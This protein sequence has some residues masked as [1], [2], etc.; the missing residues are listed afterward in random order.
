MQILKW[1]ATSGCHSNRPG[2]GK[3]VLLVQKMLFE[4]YLSNGIKTFELCLPSGKG[5]ILI[6]IVT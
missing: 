4:A 5:V 2:S 1:R 6:E 3:W